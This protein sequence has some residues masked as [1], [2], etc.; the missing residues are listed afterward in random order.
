M[1]KKLSD[2][3]KNASVATTPTTP[4]QNPLTAAIASII[5]GVVTGTGNTVSSQKQAEN[6]R[7]FDYIENVHDNVSYS[8]WSI[9]N[10]RP[11]PQDKSNLKILV[12]QSIDGYVNTEISSLNVIRFILN[13]NILINNDANY[14]VLAIIRALFY[15]PNWSINHNSVVK[16][17]LIKTCAKCGR[18]LF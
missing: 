5:P 7:E 17:S 8:L 9:G 11:S 16:S 14:S 13:S 1:Q 4:M 18:N 15:I 3:S 12:R 6:S 2:G 10:Q